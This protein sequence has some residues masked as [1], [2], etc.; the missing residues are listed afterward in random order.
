MSADILVVDDE[1]DIQFILHSFLSA[2]GYRVEVAHDLDSALE[3]MSKRSFDMVFSDIHLGEH[4]NGLDL[5]KE[6]RRR[7]WDPYVVMITG[8]PNLETV[9]DA[10]RLGAF[11][12]LVK[13]ILR[14]PL[15]RQVKNALAHKA[16]RDEKE[17]LRRRLSAIFNSVKDAIITVDSELR[18]RE[19]NPAAEQICGLKPQDTGQPIHTMERSCAGRCHEVLTQVLRDKT[20]ANLQ[21]FNC[22]HPNQANQTVDVSASPL[23]DESN[24]FLGAV[25]VI[26]D[27]T[28]LA[29]LERNLQER[30]GF[31]D[32]IGRS[33]AMQKLYNLIESL[34][35]VETSV[36]ITGESGT[37]KELVA[38]ALHYQGARAAGPL[39]KV[40]CSGLSET[41]LESELFGHVRGAF[42]GAL[43]DKT[44]RFELAHGGTIFL[45]E[46][47]DITGH[48]QTRLLRVLQNKELERVGDTRTLKVDTRVVAATNQDLR[49]KIARGDFREDLF[50]RLKVVELRLPPLRERREDIPLLV[51]HFVKKFEGT[52]H[53]NITGVGAAA[54]KV[55]M[56]H[57][58]PGNVRELE[59]VIE[60]AFVVGKTSLIEPGDLPVELQSTETLSELEA[61]ET[62]AD[63]ENAIRQALERSAWVKSKAARLLGVSRSTLYRK[64]EEYGIPAG[65]PE[66]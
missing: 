42:T 44:G 46:I 1:A 32:I 41:L 24:Q 27:E 64:M 38:E 37:G 17:V 56:N 63:E 39:V 6:I 29:T 7:N 10:L 53:K 58:W 15:L 14:E 61:P 50:Y 66:S 12:Y 33:H 5:L 20:H 59:H 57:S 2:E 26:R 19:F 16:M 23:L 31:H 36:L 43:R 47:G 4:Q 3:L 30:L 22:V 65:D 18:I 25:L 40:N 51:D 9:Q 13:P 8:F 28:R 54:M 55:F 11:D 45:D 52:F 21:R 62:L 34:A 60:H 48:M 35:G 49:K